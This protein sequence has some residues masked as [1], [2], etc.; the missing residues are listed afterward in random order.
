MGNSELRRDAHV[1]VRYYL[2]KTE[3]AGGGGVPQRIDE[4]A[5]TILQS[6]VPFIL[7]GPLPPSQCHAR[8][9]LVPGPKSSY[10]SLTRC[11]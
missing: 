10:L 4:P 8:H 11:Q 5:Q 3:R 6:Q 1:Q 2:F 9:V 7:A